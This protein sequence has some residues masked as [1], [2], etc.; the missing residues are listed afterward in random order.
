MSRAT[1]GNYVL[2]GIGR[3]TRPGYS[4]SRAFRNNDRFWS[5]SPRTKILDWKSERLNHRCLAQVL[6]I[7]WA[8]ENAMGDV[9][10]C[11]G[12][13]F[14]ASFR[15]VS[16]PTTARIIGEPIELNDGGTAYSANDQ[17][18]ICMEVSILYG[19]W[20]WMEEDT[21][22]RDPGTPIC[23]GSKRWTKEQKCE[24]VR[25]P[26]SRFCQAMECFSLANTVKAGAVSS[27]RRLQ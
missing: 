4:H 19:P 7:I 16:S 8:Q 9:D 6:K 22:F 24:I 20:S 23:V 18:E 13:C 26:E 25:P 2:P 12:S 21:S 1:W 11:T 17:K 15:T 27:P 10:Q 14:F 3:D 5:S